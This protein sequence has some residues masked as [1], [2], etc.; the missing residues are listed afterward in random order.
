M[1]SVDIPQRGDVVI[2]LRDKV[3]GEATLEPRAGMRST[4]RALVSALTSVTA[5]IATL[6]AVAALALWFLFHAFVL[7]PL[8]EHGSQ[9]RLYANFR[10]QLANGVAPLGGKIKPGSP[11]ALI[12]TGLRGM[13]DLVVVEGTTSG[14][15]TMGPGHLPDTAL[16]GQVGESVVFGRSVTY[17]APFRDLSRLN[18]GDEIKVTTGQGVFTYRVDRIRRPGDPASPPFPENES[19]MTLVTSASGGWRSGWAPTHAI[20]LE[21]SLLGKALPAPTG[22]PTSVG[23]TSQPMRGDKAVLL[24]ALWLLGVALVTAGLVWSWR[25]WGAAQTWLV[26]LPL[27]MAVFWGASGA[28]V[29]FL[30]NLI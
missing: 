25:R 4:V 27:A 18:P 3:Q 1:S 28:A 19:K 22:R 24:P 30:P 9:A 15:L 8:Q 5:L 12:D 2:D 14:E 21:A 6:S 11:V 7:T 13:R 16:P 29:R 17:G 20:Y 23:R 10:E 26:G